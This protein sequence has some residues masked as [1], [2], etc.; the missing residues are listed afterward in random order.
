LDERLSKLLQELGEPTEIERAATELNSGYFITSVLEDDFL[1]HTTCWRRLKS[2]LQDGFLSGD[3]QYLAS[4]GVRMKHVNV[5]SFTSSKWRHLSDLPGILGLTNDCYLKIPY[6]L[7]DVVKPVVYKLNRLELEELLKGNGV[8]YLSTLTQNEEKLRREYG[9]DY[10]LY[11][12]N[13]WF[14]EQ[15]W[16]ARAD[17]VYLP[18][19]TEVYVS[20]YHQLRKAKTLT[21]LPVHLDKEMMLLKNVSNFER[22]VVKRLVRI[23]GVDFYRHGVSH[24][25]V[26]TNPAQ[27]PDGR[28]T[29]FHATLH[30]VRY[31]HAITIV[32]RL[33]NAGLQVWAEGR[34][35]K[36]RPYATLKVDLTFLYKRRPLAVPNDPPKL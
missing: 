15:E 34:P 2:I 32:K 31:L 21:S 8:H 1:Y 27:T 33:K 13:T 19:Q 29:R 18:P 14:E 11:L 24:I 9:E 16:R 20:S 22:N 4:K 35:W 5:V 17:R 28:E 23:I 12:Y 36:C 25:A 7:K 3:P 6:A 10:P 26:H 30:D